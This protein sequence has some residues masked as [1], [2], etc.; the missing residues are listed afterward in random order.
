MGWGEW[1]ISFV[2]PITRRR[3]VYWP[4][5]IRIISIGTD[6]AG[7]CRH[8]RPLFV[9]F[10][11]YWAIQFC[12]FM[13]PLFS[14]AGPLHAQLSAKRRGIT[15]S[16]GQQSP[17][18]FVICFA[19]FSAF[20][21][22]VFLN[23]PLF[24]SFSYVRSILNFMRRYWWSN[25][26]SFLLFFCFFVFFVSS[27]FSVFFSACAGHKPRKKTS[28]RRINSLTFCTLTLWES[29]LGQVALLK[30]WQFNRFLVS[31]CGHMNIPD[32]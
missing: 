9:L 20:L 14:S 7:T 2:R 15:K 22:H 19:S 32:R 17:E 25:S 30:C 26:N 16:P 6:S 24:L 3:K 28:A 29:R 11:C 12:V 13:D 23:F 1:A 18:L 10:S 21:I 4:S 8:M 27:F 5:G 31:L